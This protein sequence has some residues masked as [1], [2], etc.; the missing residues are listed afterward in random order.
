MSDSPRTFNDDFSEYHYDAVIDSPVARLGLIARQGALARI[1]FTLP[2][3]PLQPPQ[4]PLLIEAARQLQA[5]FA[6]PNFVFDLPLKLSGSAHEMAVWEQIAQIPCGE[7]RT[8]A[9]IAT[10]IGSVARA[11]GGACGQN[12]VPLIIPCHRVVAASGVGGFNAHRGGV[13][14]VPIKRQLLL[15]ETRDL[16]SDL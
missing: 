5:W 16:F 3:T 13:D 1:D 8:Y 15:K 11:V 12:P 10:A 2:D 4:D 9:D 14:W 7:T 6:D